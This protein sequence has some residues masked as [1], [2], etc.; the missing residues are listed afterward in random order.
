MTAT[1]NTITYNSSMSNLLSSNLNYVKQIPPQ[2]PNSALQLNAIPHHTENGTADLCP[3]HNDDIPLGSPK[4][5]GIK[6]PILQHSFN[7]TPT[8]SYAIISKSNSNNQLDGNGNND[9]IKPLWK[10]REILKQER[11]VYYTTLDAQGTV[12]VCIYYIYRGVL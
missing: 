12:Q 3:E 5:T 11:I 10:K 6:S 2:P 7:P 4:P 8:M 1:N 9:P